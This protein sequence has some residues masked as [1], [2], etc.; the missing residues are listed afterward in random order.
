MKLLR[1][2]IFNC[3]SYKR[4][5][6]NLEKQ[7]LKLVT[8]WSYDEDNENGSGKSSLVSKALCWWLYGRTPEGL[9]TDDVV[10]IHVKP[11]G[12]R[13]TVKCSIEGYFVGQ[14]GQTYLL[15]R[16]RNPNKLSLHV[17]DTKGT[18]KSMGG[19]SMADTQ[20]K[21]DAILG[22]DYNTFV[23]ADL[24]GQGKKANF[25]SLSSTDQRKVIEN[26]LPIQE[27][28]NAATDLTKSMIKEVANAHMAALHAEDLKRQK[29]EML[30]H[31]L[32]TAKNHYT[33]WAKE[34]KSRA[35]ELAGRINAEAERVLKLA[36]QIEATKEELAQIQVP[37]TNSFDHNIEVAQS[38][39]TEYKRMNS[40]Y[41]KSRTAT[42]KEIA[43]AELVVNKWANGFNCP[44]CRQQLPPSEYSTLQVEIEDKKTKLYGWERNLEGIDAA[45]KQTKEYLDRCYEEVSNLQ[46]AK[47][48]IGKIIAE[49]AR[50]KSKLTVLEMQAQDKTPSLQQELESLNAEVNPHDASV[51]ELRDQAAEA[52]LEYDVCGRKT[53]QL[54]AE[55]IALNY[56]R[57]EFGKTLPLRL[58]EQAVAFINEQTNSHLMN[59]QN[60]QIHTNMTLEE[61]DSG[62]LKLVAEASSDTGGQSYMALSGGEKQIVNFAVGLALA[63]LAD[64]QVKGTNSVMILDEPFE[65]LS[66]RNADCV[67]TYLQEIVKNKSSVFIISHSDSLK[68]LIPNQIHVAKR[69]GISEV[70]HGNW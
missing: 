34:H 16:Q 52:E 35:M 60:Q 20:A 1:F 23:Q 56:W 31:Q 25:F 21:V 32:G 30:Y 43:R 13:K 11:T 14:N 53:A 4:A 26:L 44:T 2:S 9:K 41:L 24:F 22:R 15:K 42:V 40:A 47:G 12:K 17:V 68:G 29:S 65:N 70:C 61:A 28:V 3:F 46:A 39:I 62:E 58:I 59:L 54:S 18:T 33:D 5:D 10:N 55:L 66:A 48:N 63:D 64:N 6:L 37:D 57:Q 8:G 36:P 7:G 45:I 69:D 51:S 50:T 38:W 67:V 49:E 27:R 19:T